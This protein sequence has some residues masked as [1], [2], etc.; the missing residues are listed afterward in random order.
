MLALASN[1]SLVGLAV[2]QSAAPALAMN[3]GDPMMQKINANYDHRLFCNYVARTAVG[4]IITH[5][6]LMTGID[7]DNAPIQQSTSGGDGR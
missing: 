4:M 6:E 3:A 7:D 2:K 5:R 1:A